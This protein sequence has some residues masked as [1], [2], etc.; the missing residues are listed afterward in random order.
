MGCDVL[1]AAAAAAEMARIQALF[2]L[3]DR[4][5]SRFLPGSELNRVNAAGGGFVSVSALFA[6]ALATALEMAEETDGLFDPTVGA[7]VVAA[8]YD[9]DFALLGDDPR[10]VAVAAGANWRSVH[11]RGRL[12]RLPAHVKLDLN[13]VVKAAAADAAAGLISAGGWVSAGGDIA[14]TVP[15]EVALPGGGAVR[16]ERGGLATSGRV[17]RRW[18]RAGVEQHHLI[19]PASGRPST[20]P[21]LQVTVCGRTCLEADVAAKAAYL[22]GASGPDW[23]AARSLAGR[24]L[25]G[26]GETV[27]GAWGR[28]LA[29]S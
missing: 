26:D 10:P 28:A 14:A 1:V 2:V 21:W 5:F 6:G 17:K 12:V 25:D 11:V 18:R 9:R 13:G 4:T 7:A 29:C 16:L 20:S 22:A 24:F 27:S 8:G 23:L 19:D 3:H 15:V